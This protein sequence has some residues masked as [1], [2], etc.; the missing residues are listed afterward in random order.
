MLVITCALDNLC[1]D[2]EALAEKIKAAGKH[3][4]HRRMAECDHAWDKQYKPGTVQE[5]AK[6][7]VYDLAVEMLRT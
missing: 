7:D 1:L 6:D 3:L 2:A 4:V 5:K